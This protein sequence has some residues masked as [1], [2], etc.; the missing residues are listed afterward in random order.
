MQTEKA[1]SKPPATR[2][3][4][5]VERSGANKF[6]DPYRWLEDDSAETAA[7]AEAQHEHTR[8][9]LAD[10][11]SRESLRK[12]FSEL[13]SRDRQ[14]QVIEA[15]GRLFQ[16]WRQA[17]AQRW[18][19]W[20]GDQLEGDRRL[21]IDP[22]CLAEQ[23]PRL[24]DIHPSPDG[25]FVAFRL[26]HAGSSL[27]PLH[28]VDVQTGNWLDDIIPGDHNPV[29]QL[30]HSH[31]RVAWNGD[32][33][34][35]YYS[36]NPGGLAGD[37][38]RYY[39]KLYLHRLGSDHSDDELV[40]GEGLGREW[41]LV[42]H[43]SAD[44]RF[45]VVSLHDFSGEEPHSRLLMHDARQ[46]QRG[47]TSLVD[48]GPGMLDI[49]VHQGFVFAKTNRDARRW[50]LQRFAL[51]S[52]DHRPET[53]VAEGEHN[54]G[55][56][57]PAGSRLIVERTDE[58]GSSLGVH[59]LSG[60]ERDRVALNGDESL[61][62]L[63]GGPGG[64][65]CL[66][67]VA[68]PCS[69]PTVRQLDLRTPRVSASPRPTSP[70]PELQIHRAH[71]TSADGTRVPLHLI[72]RRDLQRDGNNPAVLRGY[73]GFQVSLTPT[74]RPDIL[75][76]LEHGGVYAVA[77]VRGG[78][79]Q[80]ED[81]H[82]GGM[83]EYKQNSFDDFA[84]AGEWLVAQGYAHPQRLGCFGW[85]N[86]GLLANVTALQRPS[87]WRAVVAGAPVTDMARFHLAHGAR[88][89]IAEYGSPE[90]DDELAVMLRYSPYHNVPK[91]IDAPAIMIYAPDADDRVAAWHGR[92]MLA[93]WQA[94][95]RSNHPV[96]LRGAKN[97]GH[98]GGDSVA[99][100][101]TKYTDIW[102]FLFWQLGVDADA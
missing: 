57:A 95:N 36:R 82:R 93:Q 45:L 50:Q 53:I 28:V 94:A 62:W 85:S 90:R 58:A 15:G 80:G 98:H 46:R 18:S 75:P 39:Q 86:G 97:T 42:P 70:Y 21:L 40:L 74:W 96:L 52:S 2:R 4:S 5:L 59:D 12:R 3:T 10:L 7:W 87:L 31:N 23:P 72:H 22:D 65:R 64:T 47:F 101:T 67:G 77:N 81:W 38:R 48:E 68:S 84:A 73:G 34:G 37:E 33:S 63:T 25:R 30:W 55:H 92:K 20:V 6:A 49:A 89:W 9:T 8:Q 83:R 41:T 51:D 44:D 17:G 43:L 100:L 56:W 13:L 14:G 26:S 71:C 60:N 16:R 66:F 54:I 102:S 79:E 24:A 88:H 69:P 78:G 32:S 29:A 19:L 61:Q 76:F 99:Q 91:A 27:M 1:T 35:F 11:P